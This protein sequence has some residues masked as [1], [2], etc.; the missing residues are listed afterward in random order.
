MNKMDKKISSSSNSSVSTQDVEETPIITLIP[1]DY[2]SNEGD[3]FE[4]S[5]Q[6]SI[7]SSEL[8]DDSDD[9]SEIIITS[10]KKLNKNSDKVDQNIGKIII[11]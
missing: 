6:N 9:E 1:C 3:D 4:N 5:S 7:D 8:S 11:A 2:Y 10:F